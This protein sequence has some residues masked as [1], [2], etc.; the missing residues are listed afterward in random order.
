MPIRLQNFA[1]RIQNRGGAVPSV[2]RIRLVN[3]QAKTGLS[4]SATIQIEYGILN[5]DCISNPYSK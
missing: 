2:S 4:G 5:L 1:F 3:C